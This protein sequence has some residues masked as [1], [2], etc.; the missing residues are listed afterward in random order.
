MSHRMFTRGVPLLTA[1][2]LV[3]RHV[4]EFTLTTGESM[5]P[6]IHNHGD[7]IH[8]IKW[9]NV[10]KLQMGDVVILKKPSDPQRR[11]CKRITGLPG[12]IVCVDPSSA[13]GGSIYSKLSDNIYYSSSDDG[14]DLSRMFLKVPKGHIW[15]TGDNLN[16]SMDSRDYGMVPIGLILGKVLAANNLNKPIYENGS[17]FGFRWLKNS[18][19]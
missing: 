9:F 6:T 10:N 8:V 4:Y 5:L 15:V 14:T 2:Y 19:N 12:D 1:F 11:V 7:F 18:Y 3:H 13:K 17:F 16:M